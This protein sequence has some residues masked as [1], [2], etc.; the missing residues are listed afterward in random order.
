MRKKKEDLSIILKENNFDIALLQDTKI[1][2]NSQM[3]FDGY[4]IIRKDRNQNGGGVR[5]LLKKTSSTV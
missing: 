4:N 1:P 3:A 5:T 2:Q